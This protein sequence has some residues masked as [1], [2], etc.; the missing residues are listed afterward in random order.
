MV[1]LQLCQYRCPL[2]DALEVGGMALGLNL[3]QCIIGSCLL[4]C[5]GLVCL[6]VGTLYVYSV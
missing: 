6:V 3:F 4:S 2:L 5:R 1:L